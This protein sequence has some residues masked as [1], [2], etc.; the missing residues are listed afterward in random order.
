[1]RLLWVSNVI[2]LILDPCLIFGWASAI[3]FKR[4]GWK[5]QKI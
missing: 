3:L 4:G 2:N 1:M 5:I